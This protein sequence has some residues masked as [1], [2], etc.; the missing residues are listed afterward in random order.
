FL[1]HV[2]VGGGEELR[3]RFQ[4]GDVGTQAAPHRTHFQADDASPDDRQ[5]FR[6]R[7]DVERADVVADDLVVY[8]N[9]RQ[10]AGLGAG[11][12]DHLLGNHG[13]LADLHLPAFGGLFDEGAVTV[14]QGD[15][16]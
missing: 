15:L 8:W 4:H 14:E 3:Q 9:V 2:L 12:D 13:L 16:V 5:L 1:G 10:M 11:G 6:H 7:V